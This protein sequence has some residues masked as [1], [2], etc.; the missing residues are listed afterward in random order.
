MQEIDCFRTQL[1][2]LRQEERLFM[3]FSSEKYCVIQKIVVPLHRQK[4]KG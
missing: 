1:I 2:D 3:H 4:T